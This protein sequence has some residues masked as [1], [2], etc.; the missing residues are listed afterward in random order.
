[1]AQQRTI[2]I[3]GA[4]IGGLTAALALAQRGFRTVVFEQAEQL[5][6]AGAGIQLSP[7]A[8]RLLIGL[9]LGERLKL[10]ALCPQSIRIRNGR[11]GDVIATIPLAAAEK[12]YGAP[13]WVIHRGDLQNVLLE[14]AR[15]HHDIEIRLGVRIENFAPYSAGV[16]VQGMRGA[17]AVN[18]EGIAFIG[19]DGLWSM[20]RTVFADRQVPR[21]AKRVA[22]RAVV[23]PD[24]VRPEFR[25]PHIT[26]WLGPRGHLV[27]Y[28]VKGGRAINIVAITS[29]DWSESGWSAQSPAAEV[30]QY[31]APAAWCAEARSVVH[32]PERW[33]KWALFDRPPIGVWGEGRSTLLGDAAHPML[34][35]MAQGAAAAIEDATVLA[36]CFAAQRE[37]PVSALRE[38]EGKRHRRTAAM[39]NTARR[40]DSFYHYRGPDA[41]ARDLVLR[42]LGGQRLLNRYDW[43]FDWQP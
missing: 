17:E 35:F 14:A 19:A 21:F 36:D 29:G 2:I 11:R 32:A 30:S 1:V 18:A 15:E 33:L 25:E 34:P 42:L 23:A 8:S 38:Y 6:E 40:N 10:E 43:I 13:Y 7:N 3:A 41:W 5:R 26:L 9:G 27:H 16:T 22:W 31:F 12:R 20:A 4:G 24:A 28:P 39:Q 37:A